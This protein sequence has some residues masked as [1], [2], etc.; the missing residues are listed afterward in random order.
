MGPYETRELAA[1]AL[2]RARER[3]E[4]MDQADLDWDGD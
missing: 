1:T 4:Q 2:A 3:T